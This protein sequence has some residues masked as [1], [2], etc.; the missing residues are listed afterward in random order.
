VFKRKSNNDGSPLRVCVVG[1][2]PRFLSGLAYYTHRMAGALAE[3]HRISVLLLRQLLPTRLYPGRDRVGDQLVDF[4]YP[5]G[6]RVFN[7]IDWFWGRTILLAFG[8]LRRERPDV[9]IFHWWTGTVLHSYIALALVARMLG[10]RVV[11]EFHEV[12]DP[13]ELAMP[14]ANRY[15]KAFAPLLV[16]L[17]DGYLVHNEHDRDELGRVYPL[18]GKPVAV[19][20][21]GPYDQYGTVADV[22]RDADDVC[23][24][25]FFGLIRP[26]KGVEELL[27]AFDSLT[28]EEAAKF[29]LTIVGETWEGYDAPARAIEDS[30]HRDR[31][32]FI[33]RYVADDEVGHFFA[34]ADAVVLPYRRGSA[35]GPLH[36][37]MSRGLPLL[38]TA[39]GG[40][41]AAA[42]DYEGAV[43]IPPQDPDAIREG[44]QALY[45]LRGRRFEDVHSWDTTLDRYDELFEQVGL[46]A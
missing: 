24:L 17:C 12:Q 36:L 26:Y 25:L 6:T 41:V 33:N 43:M 2:G 21:H 1:P 13:S 8:L 32:E 10:I 4:E 31:I 14:L 28:P 9:I 40:L 27:E 45:A 46:A 29:R 19:A 34:E 42:Q 3:R 39:V 30:R 23:R 5:A 18:G 22:Q 15:V 16:R 37:A 44:L 38:V 11:M 35:S 7:G 20:A